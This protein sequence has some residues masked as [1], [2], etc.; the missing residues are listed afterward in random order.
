MSGTNSIE[1]SQTKFEKVSL[2]DGVPVHLD[3][4]TEEKLRQYEDTE[5]LPPNNS[6][7]GFDYQ[8]DWKEEHEYFTSPGN[9]KFD[10]NCTEEVW[11]ITLV[12]SSLRKNTIYLTVSFKYVV[13]SYAKNLD[14]NIHNAIIEINIQ[15]YKT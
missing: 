3:N 13:H 1:S 7:Q 5:T 10:P 12:P 6:P 14:Y 11:N 8:M 9:I 4:D 2:F 15:S